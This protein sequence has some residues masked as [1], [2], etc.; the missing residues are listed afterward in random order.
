[1]KPHEETWV[2][3]GEQVGWVDGPDPDHG[4]LRHAGEFVSPSYDDG[5]A[6]ARLAAQAPAM[7][8]VLLAIEWEGRTDY[9]GDGGYD[10]CPACVAASRRGT[11]LRPTRRM[12]WQGVSRSWAIERRARST[13]RYGKRGCDEQRLARACRQLLGPSH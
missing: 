12:I 3:T 5:V 10:D 2:A 11:R 8:R 13:S 1:M 6:R 7:A 9:V 4:D